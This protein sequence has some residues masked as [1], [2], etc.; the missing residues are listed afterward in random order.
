MTGEAPDWDPHNSDWLQQEASMTDLRGQVKGF[1]YDVVARGQ[2]LI[3]SV[4]C[5][6]LQINPTDC[7][8]FADALERSVRVCWAK[9]SRG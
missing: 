3:N 4:S 6:H 5:S 2:R 9:T 7:K 1:D 8:D